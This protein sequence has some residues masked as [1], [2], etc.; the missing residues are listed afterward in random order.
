MARKRI[1]KEI[2]DYNQDPPIF[3]CS[4]V[5][6]ENSDIF[7]WKGIIYGPPDS[8][9]ED[10]F[11]NFDI[12]FPNDYPFKPPNFKF[13]TKIFHPNICNDC[14]G[15]I[16]LDIL[17]DQWSPAFTIKK[18]IPC[19]Y[20]MLSDPNPDGYNGTIMN[21]NASS[22]YKTNRSEYNRIAHE[23]AIKYAG[24]RRN[25]K[26][27]E[28]HKNHNECKDNK[29]NDD[30]EENEE[31]E[32]NISSNRDKE[33]NNEINKDIIGQKKEIIKINDNNITLDNNKPIE[34]GKMREELLDQLKKLENLLEKEKEKNNILTKEKLQLI[35]VI[36]EEKNKNKSL[37][38]KIKSM[39]DFL[40]KN[41]PN[42]KEN[43]YDLFRAFL[44]KDKEINLLKMKLSNFPLELKE[45]E[46]LISIIITNQEENILYSI[47]CKDTNNFKDIEYK[48]HDKYPEFSELNIYFT[49]NGKRI[50]INKSL[51]ENKIK[52][53]SIIV[54]NINK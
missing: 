18:L 41:N 37:I 50:N 45:G 7:H 22:L 52:D 46:K 23:W 5:P 28:E 24:A 33:G 17:I 20:Y 13:K 27:I 1:E 40:D 49:L 34:E 42:L 10:G 9:Y 53:N 39:E 44:D 47:I 48:I 26:Y 8:P 36:N 12:Y 31:D 32:N 19:I 38:E 16:C 4:M 43:K 29:D 6:P 35:K 25:P 11:F 51:K 14:C 21:S 30:D 54:L 3:A 2:R 15:K